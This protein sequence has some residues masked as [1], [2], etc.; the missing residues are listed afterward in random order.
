MEDAEVFAFEGEAEIAAKPFELHVADDQVGLAGS[1]VGNDGALYVWENGLHVRFVEAE[2]RGAV[3]GHA[4]H[5][6]DE[7]ALNV[8]ERGVLVEVLAIDGG[9]D[10]DD[11]CEHQEAAIAFVGFHYEILAFAEAR[12]GAC[13]IH[14]ATNH[15]CR[16]EMRGAK[17]RSDH[18]SRSRLA[19]R[20][21]YG[22]AIFQAHQLREHLGARDDGDLSFVRFDDFGIVLLD[23]RRGHYDVRAF[24]VDGFVAFVDRGAEILQALGDVRGFGVRAGNGIAQRQQDFGDAAHAD[25]ADTDQVNALKIAERDHHGFALW[26][27]PCTFAASSIRLT[28]SRVALGRASD[29][30]CGGLLFDLF[31]VIDQ[32]EDFVRQAFRGEFVFGDQTACACAC[33]FLRVA[34]LVAVGGGSEGNEDGGAARGCDFRRGDGSCSANDHICPGKAFRH[35]RKEGDDLRV[36][37]AP[38]VGGAHGIIIAF[39]GLMHDG[40]L[41][42]SA[43]QGGPWRRRTCG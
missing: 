8:R 15:K 25:A 20:A 14:F 22:D 5:E 39:A 16:I 40:E 33:H 43:R 35:I 6:L 38:R 28:M 23:R 37:F 9:D 21:G 18:R 26:R 4:V 27:F 31:R 42:F 41:I 29:A 7:G 24:D 11:G 17:N 19:V 30:R 13:L 36:D 3:E 12:G 10:G 34:Q 2:N 32:G 1:A